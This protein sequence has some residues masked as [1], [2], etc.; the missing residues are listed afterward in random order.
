[1]ACEIHLGEY[2]DGELGAQARRR[3]EAHLRDCAECRRRVE[4]EQAIIDR[5]FEEGWI[6]A[7]PPPL[8]TGK[9]VA[10]IGSGPAGLACADELATSTSRRTTMIRRRSLMPGLAGREY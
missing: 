10:V 2:L 3:L 4:L 9:R 1:M 5:A 6:A 8:R 7:N